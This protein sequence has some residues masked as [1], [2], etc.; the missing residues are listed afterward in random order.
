M[1]RFKLLVSAVLLGLFAWRTDWAKV[2]DV[3]RNMRVEMWLAALGVYLGAQVLSSFRWQWMARALGFTQPLGHFAGFYFIGM[4]FNLV[5]PTSVGGDVIRACY[6]DQGSGR[7]LDAFLSVFVDRF[8]GLLVLLGL[9]CTAV[10]FCP[11]ALPPWVF[12]SVWGTAAAAAVGLAAMAISCWLPEVGYDVDRPVGR[13]TAKF[14]NLQRTARALPAVYGRRPGMVL[15]TTLLSVGV[16][17]ANVLVVWLVGQA[18]DLPVPGAY[19]WI[20]VPMVS[21]LCVLPL[22]VN[23]MGI[24]EGGVCLFLAPL[25]VPETTALSLAFL[26]FAAV[27]AANLSGGFVYLFGS[28]PRPEL[29][30]DDEPVGDYSDQGRARES[31]AA[32]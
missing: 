6:L 22:S 8:S 19:Y 23:G 25:Q 30:A 1:K 13:W 29:R 9:A 17:V 31:A 26:W 28:F 21:L 4:F 3:F 32:A 5:L 12:W 20:L 24:R 10:F 7:R 27:V 15:G 2:A 14:A 18:L 16:Q 11:L